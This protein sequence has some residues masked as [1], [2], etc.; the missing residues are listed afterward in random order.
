MADA[1][2]RASGIASGIDTSYL[3]EELTKMQR[4]PLNRLTTRQ[5]AFTRQV[6]SLGDISS[7]MNALQAAAKKL[8][9][10][11]GLGLRST[12]SPTGFSVTPTTTAVAG[13][14]EVE[15]TN[16]A[17]NA[18]ALSGGLATASLVKAGTLKLGVQ[19]TNYDIAMGEGA[20][21]QDVANAIKASNAPVSAVVLNDGTSNYLSITRKESGY[22]IGSAASAGLTVS[23]NYTGSTGEQLSFAVVNAENAQFSVNGLDFTRT[24]NSVS[25]AIPGAEMTLKAKGGAAEIVQLEND[26]SKTADNL[27]AFVDA[28]NSVM[29]SVSDNLKPSAGTDRTQTL[30][31]DASLRSLQRSLQ[32]VVTN[33]VSGLSNVRTLADLGLK[34]AQSDGSLSIDN[35]ALSKALE[36]DA[37]ALNKIFSTATS[38]V[39]AVV[40]DLVTRFTNSSDGILTTRRNGINAQVKGMG[41]QIEKMELRIESFRST[42]VNQFTA[43]EKTLSALK[44]TGSFLSTQSRG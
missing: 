13:R 14:Y 7:K 30:A 2:F 6:S 29:K 22:T 4:I 36:R 12:G 25:D 23:A 20:T 43:M 40:E 38:G 31:G 8:S 11:G 26:T 41:A 37:E 44:A 17:T 39:A 24:S 18:R 5:T 10:S 1:M 3:V 15:V 32:G 42:L 16:L 35:A 33:M 21:L 19:G 34:T 28:Y 27:K 9:T